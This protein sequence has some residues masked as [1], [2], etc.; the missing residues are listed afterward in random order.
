MLPEALNRI[1]NRSD[2]RPSKVVEAW[3]KI[4]GLKMAEMARA[5]SFENGVLTVIVRSSSL[6]SSLCQHEKPRLLDMLQQQF[7][8]NQVRNINFRIG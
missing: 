4:I 3:P 7:P 1:Q 8:K 2:S 5:V 6:Y